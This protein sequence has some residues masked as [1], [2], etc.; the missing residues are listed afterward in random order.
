M[1]TQPMQGPVPRH[2]HTKTSMRSNP[3]LPSSLHSSVL[4]CMTL[5]PVKLSLFLFTYLSPNPGHTRQK[6]GAV[7]WCEERDR[8]RSDPFPCSG[9]VTCLWPS[10]YISS[11]PLLT[12]SHTTGPLTRSPLIT[13][14]G[15]WPN[16]GVC[17]GRDSCS[18]PLQ[19]KYPFYPLNE[20]I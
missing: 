15:I 19:S 17:V 9:T 2:R 20:E 8:D 7:K 6:W 12:A 16:L 4:A 18:S 11:F 14:C 3:Y 10:P 13:C 1:L 5:D